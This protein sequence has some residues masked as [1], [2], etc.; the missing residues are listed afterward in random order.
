MSKSFTPADVAS[1]NTADAG[2]YIIVDSNVYDVTCE[3]SLNLHLCFCHTDIQ[4]SVRRRA[5]RWS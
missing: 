3:Q 5:S 2:L 4:V 1:H